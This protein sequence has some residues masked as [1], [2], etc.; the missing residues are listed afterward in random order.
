M[1]NRTVVTV[2]KSA[3]NFLQ[4]FL[5]QIYQMFKIFCDSY[6]LENVNCFYKVALILIQIFFIFVWIIFTV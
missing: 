4:F 2:T 5:R 1:L 3:L 6:H